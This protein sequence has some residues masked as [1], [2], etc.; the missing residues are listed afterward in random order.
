M[1]KPFSINVKAEAN[2]DIL[3]NALPDG[4]TLVLGLVTSLRNSERVRTTTNLET[5]CLREYEL[6]SYLE[7]TCEAFRTYAHQGKAISPVRA[8]WT[9]PECPV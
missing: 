6:N 1:E 9:I 3:A 4:H 5:S 2:M 8:A 7:T